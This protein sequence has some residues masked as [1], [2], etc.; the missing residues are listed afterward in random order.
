MRNI[1]VLENKLFDEHKKT[2]IQDLQE[3]ENVSIIL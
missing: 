1:W 2:G 3:E